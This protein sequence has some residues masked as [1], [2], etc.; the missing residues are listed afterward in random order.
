VAF[1]V[2]FRS[3]PGVIRLICAKRIQANTLVLMQAVVVYW[4][5][6]AEAGYHL[7]EIG[8][9]RI[10]DPL[11]SKL[12]LT[13]IYDL[14]E[15]ETGA[16]WPQ[17]QPYFI[18]PDFRRLTYRLAGSAARSGKREVLSTRG[19]SGLGSL[20]IAYV[21]DRRGTV[22]SITETGLPN[23]CITSVSRGALQYQGAGATEPV[24]TSQAAGLVYR[25]LPGTRLASTDDNERLAI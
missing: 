15:L 12:R 2:Q 14:S 18:K 23:D 17:L 20:D 21:A 1:A 5:P 11:L 19:A 16:Y 3:P 22:M 10:G 13:R 25:G 7:M 9:S 4:P 24:S 6:P 8:I